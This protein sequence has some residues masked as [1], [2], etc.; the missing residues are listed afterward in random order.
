MGKEKKRLEEG[1][2]V[3]RRKMRVDGGKSKELHSLSF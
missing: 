2:K 3:G 1:R